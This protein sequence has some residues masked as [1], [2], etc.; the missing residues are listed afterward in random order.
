M[1]AMPPPLPQAKAS[2]LKNR[3]A[4]TDCVGAYITFNE[5]ESRKRCL[6][7]YHEYSGWYELPH[8]C[9]I[10]LRGA[11]T[12]RRNT[13]RKRMCMPYPMR[14]RGKY[15]LKVIPAPEPSDVIWEN[16]DTTACERGCRR[17]AAFLIMLVR[18]THLHAARH[19]AWLTLWFAAPLQALLLLS[20]LVIFVASL[21][22]IEAS[23]RLPDFNLCSTELPAVYHQSRFFDAVRCSLCASRQGA[24]MCTC[25]LRPRHTPVSESSPH[26]QPH[27]R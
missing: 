12:V 13:T 14:F 21:N 6:N 18:P 4:S 22:K 17:C 20:I 16:L 5:V 23:R 10:T 26:P 2:K 19:L 3:Q 7:D 1:S 8:H 25:A 9:C 15:K 11:N 24:H 27:R